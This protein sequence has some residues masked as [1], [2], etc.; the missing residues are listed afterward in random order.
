[1]KDTIPI[2]NFGQNLSSD[3]NNQVETLIKCIKLIK[4]I[5]FHIPHKLSTYL[6]TYCR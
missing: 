4:T 1:M 5:T 2:I 6:E 3:Y